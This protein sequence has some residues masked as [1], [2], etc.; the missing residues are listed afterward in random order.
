MDKNIIEVYGVASNYQRALKVNKINDKWNVVKAHYFTLTDDEGN[1]FDAWVL[2][3]NCLWDIENGHH[4]YMRGTMNEEGLFI[5]G[6][7]DRWGRYCD[8]CGKHH[9]EGYYVNEHLYACSEECG[10]ALVGGKLAFEETFEYDEDGELA[11]DSPT[12]WTEWEC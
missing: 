11:E 10:Y 5:A 8:H 6:Y 9:T 2:E 1:S 4:Y 3:E 7:L 12:Y